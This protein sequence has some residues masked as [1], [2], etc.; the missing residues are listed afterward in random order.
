VL[1]VTVEEGARLVVVPR[2]PP[3]WTGYRVTIRP[4]GGA[5]TWRI[6]VRNPGGTAGPPVSATVDG[7]GV[8]IVDSRVVVPLVDDGALH[9]VEVTLG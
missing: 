8:Q 6:D 5:T 7:R 1:G 3:E 4:L 9:R 2:I